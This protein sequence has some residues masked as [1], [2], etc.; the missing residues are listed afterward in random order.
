MELNIT[1]LD[2]IPEF[3]KK[4][5]DGDKEAMY[6]WIIKILLKTICFVYLDRIDCFFLKL[7]KYIDKMYIYMVYL[8]CKNLMNKRF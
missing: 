5:K 2:N 4:V 8:N 6:S 1:R 7:K 3:I